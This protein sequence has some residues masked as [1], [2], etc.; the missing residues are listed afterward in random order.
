MSKG[1]FRI[2]PATVTIYAAAFL[3]TDYF[4][5]RQEFKYVNSLIWASLLGGTAGTAH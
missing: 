4:F 3:A 2:T 1:N 5:Y